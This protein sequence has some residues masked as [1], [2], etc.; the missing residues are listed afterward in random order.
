[1]LDTRDIIILTAAFY[2]GD[3][4]SKFFAALNTDIVTPILAP[5]ASAGKG[6]AS[7]SVT[8]GSTKLMVGDVISNLVNLIVSFF[9]VV[10]VIGLL[11]TYV[12]TR[13]GAGKAAI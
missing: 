2:L 1:M 13:I 10:V 8:I 12:L 11:R 4:V 9:L 6:V 5:A 3:V 7:F